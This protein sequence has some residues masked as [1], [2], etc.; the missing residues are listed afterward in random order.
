MERK[1]FLEIETKKNVKKCIKQIDI[2]PIRDVLISFY[3]NQ[4]I[5]TRTTNIIL[6]RQYSMNLMLKR[7]DDNLKEEKTTGNFISGYKK[8]LKQIQRK[9]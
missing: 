4:K 9:E 5:L 3:S 1:P 6:K 7:L 2:I 8:K